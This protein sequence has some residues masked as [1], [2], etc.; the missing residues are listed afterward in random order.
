MSNQKVTLSADLSNPP[1]YSLWLVK[2]IET[3][4]KLST[5]NLH[6][7]ADVYHQDIVFI[8]PMHQLEGFEQL[9]NYFNELY[10]KLSYCEFNIAF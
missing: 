6:L 10:Q 4:Q 9:K 3:Y 1:Q 2:F 8:D 7:L 5:D